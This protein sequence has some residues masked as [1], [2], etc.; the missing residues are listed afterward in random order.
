MY[1]G[2]FLAVSSTLSH[3]STMKHFF[4]VFMPFYAINIIPIFY[5]V[6]YML[7]ITAMVE[8]MTNKIKR[9]SNES[10]IRRIIDIYQ[11]FQKTLNYPV[12]AMFT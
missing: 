1:F 9:A 11:H 5:T 10:I 6:L 3:H 4:Y 2:N 8:N 12:F 7:L